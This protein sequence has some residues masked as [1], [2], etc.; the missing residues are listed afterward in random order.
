MKTSFYTRA[1][2]GV[3]R[4]EMTNPEKNFSG[5]KKYS[6]WKIYGYQDKYFSNKL[7]KI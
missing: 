1:P 2:H 4:E 5:V 3:H 6:L 7:V